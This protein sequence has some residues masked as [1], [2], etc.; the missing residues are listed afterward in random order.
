MINLIPQHAKRS[1]KI[2]YLSR[3]LTVTFAA[4]SC[5]LVAASVLLVPQ[6][7]LL[8]SQNSA[9]S[10]QYEASMSTKQA[11][12]SY[13]TQIKNTNQAIELVH[14][15]VIIGNLVPYI[16]HIQSYESVGV[17]FDYIKV[18]RKA[19]AGVVIKMAGMA[20]TRNDLA[21]LKNSLVTDPVIAE[22]D[23]PLENLA[24]DKDLPFH[25]S[26]EVLPLENNL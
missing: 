8:H 20:A 1:I 6:L 16:K 19:D 17:T 9:L 26:L 3:L 7:V 23:L 5:V 11:I 2:E 10:Q 13:V 4:L 25:I 12:D 21:I 14:Q 24:K 22:V 15:V 18:D